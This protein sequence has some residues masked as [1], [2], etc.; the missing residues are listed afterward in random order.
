MTTPSSEK[1]FVNTCIHIIL[2]LYR[3]SVSPKIY[4]T[5]NPDL[6]EIKKKR[7]LIILQN[8]RF[9]RHRPGN[10]VITCH[11][12][13]IFLR[14]SYVMENGVFALYPV[15][16][17]SLEP[18]ELRFRSLVT[19][20]SSYPSIEAMVGTTEPCHNVKMTRSALS[21]APHFK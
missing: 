21:D 9:L 13:T 7:F 4:R 19:M 15:L 18:V 8:T 16:C 5:K 11:P 2:G 12:S 6:S 17:T 1:R 10:K 14:S 20:S 3:G